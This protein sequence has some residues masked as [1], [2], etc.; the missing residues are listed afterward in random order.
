M[1]ALA[2]LIGWKMALHA[3]PGRRPDRRSSPP[4]GES[5]RYPS[6]TPV[7]FERISGHRDGDS[8]SCPGDVL[9]GQLADLRA[10]ARALRRAGRRR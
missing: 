7:P 2:R 1:D 9:Y 3:A 8:T 10:R 4:G 6:G 5:N